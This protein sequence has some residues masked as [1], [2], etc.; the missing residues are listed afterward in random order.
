[1]IFSGKNGIFYCAEQGKMQMKK[2]IVIGCPGSGKST[3][4]RVLRDKTGIE[5]FYLDMMFWNADKTTVEKSVFYERL[6]SVLEKDE[7]IID[8]NYISTMETRILSCDT[9]FFLDYPSDV[10]LDGVRRRIGTQREDM[11]WVETEEDTEFTEFIKSFSEKQR[12]RI[13]ELL[14][15]YSAKNITVFRSREE[16]DAFLMENN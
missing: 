14:E 7:W 10:C 5:L 6:N 13:I 12:P 3:F 4:S 8:G 9:V 2:I 16:A 11:P 15:K 1:L